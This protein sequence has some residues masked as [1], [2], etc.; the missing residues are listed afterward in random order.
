MLCNN[1]T[2]SGYGVCNVYENSAH[3]VYTVDYVYNADAVYNV[4][5][6]YE[7][8]LQTM[9]TMYTVMMRLMYKDVCGVYDVCE[10]KMWI[11]CISY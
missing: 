4:C 10:R 8:H 9:C 2:R 11:R 6:V 5:N 3:D 7:V 1:Q